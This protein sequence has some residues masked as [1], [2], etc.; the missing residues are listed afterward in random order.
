MIIEDELGV[1]VIGMLVAGNWRTSLVWGSLY[2]FILDTNVH[3]F[4]VNCSWLIVIR[5][6]S[7]V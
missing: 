4:E 7:V 1:V 6:S 5:Y 3:C 2:V